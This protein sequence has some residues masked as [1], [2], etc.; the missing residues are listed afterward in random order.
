MFSTKEAILQ[1]EQENDKIDG[2]LIE[3]LQQFE[4]LFVV[5]N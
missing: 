3:E 2:V 5:F 1:E 4:M